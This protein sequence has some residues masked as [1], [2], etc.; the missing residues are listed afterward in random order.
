MYSSSP[1]LLIPTTFP[2]SGLLFF[3]LVASGCLRIEQM[4]LKSFYVAKILFLV[5]VCLELVS[6]SVHGLC[7]SVHL[8]GLAAVSFIC[9]HIIQMVF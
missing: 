2:T 8:S 1:T 3:F 4:F 7:P 9:S 5:T 6:K